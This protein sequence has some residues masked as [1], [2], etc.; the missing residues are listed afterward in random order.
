MSRPHTLVHYL[1]SW[2]QRR[3]DA[4][5]L[6]GKI[7]GAWN[8]RTWRRYWNDVCDVAK[9][10]IAAGL[11]PGECVAIVGAN[12][13]EWVVAQ[14]GIMAARGVPAP[15]Y[16]T[17]TPA[18]SAWIIRNA[19]ARIVIC[20]GGEQLEKVLALRDDEGV[21]IDTVVTM[22]GL[23]HEDP[24]VVSLS[25]LMERG[26]AVDPGELDARLRELS[27][28]ETALLIYTSGT[29]GTPKGV[30]LDHGGML[31]V[32]EGLVERYPELGD[33]SRYR[34]VS[35]LPLCHAAEQMASVM[36]HL[37][38]G[39]EVSFC[40]DMN[41]LKEYLL[42]VRPTI[43]LGV[44]RVWEKFETA[45]RAKLGEAKGPKAKLAKWALKTE[46]AGFA[47]DVY[48]GR[49]TSSAFRALGRALVISKIKR[50]LGLDRIVL[51]ATGAAPTSIET[52]KFFASLGIVI[53][54]GY[55]MSETS[56]VATSVDPMRP[57]LGTVGR[58]LKGIEVRIADDGE[59]L[60]R[61]RAVSRGY[62]G[63]PEE[64]AELW[65]DDGWLRTG[66]LGELDDEGNLKITGRKKD[67]IITAGG[68][69]VA[70]S[71][72]EALVSRVPGVSQAVVV[73]D[74]RPYLVALLTLD[75]EALPALRER[76]GI[77]EADT[78]HE[79]PKL[80]EYL[81][82]EIETRCNGQLA[83]YQS[84][85]RFAI[86]EDEFSVEGGQ[87]TPTMKVKRAVVNERYAE[88]IEALYGSR[89][90]LRLDASLG[91]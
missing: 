78:L 28:R 2:A 21:T 4:P 45:L 30:M 7:A 58:A 13:M 36:G 80:H 55:G 56:G 86:L 8:T 29:T 65:T 79:H 15:I 61:G 77:E 57:R 74:R 20:D 26:R 10:L 88:H 31:S 73:G 14:L 44:P 89:P 69:N 34:V 49:P 3:P 17:N 5:A 51:A 37:R 40:P 50:A 85:K 23:L 53:Y 9:G 52:L 82:R 63:M 72:I 25:E 19:G 75:S 41:E 64:S 84:I 42:E 32:A 71:E 70:P 48:A 59:I 16:V 38:S 35:Y 24:G 27:D 60:F 22:D 12:R 68:K 39:G 6:H 91:G 33:S 62:F 43:F 1:R 67:L 81:A 87:L 18:Q 66:D 54:E 76:L 47:R 90:G 83:R 11:R 46:A